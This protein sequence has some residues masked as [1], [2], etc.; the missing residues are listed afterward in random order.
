MYTILSN[1]FA[2][3]LHFNKNM[4]VNLNALIRYKTIDECLSNPLLKCTIEILI[5]RCSEKISDSLGISTSVSE[6]TIRNDIRILRSD[7]LGFNAPI[8]VENGVY[9]YSNSNYRLHNNDVTD[10][11]LLK[12]IQSLLIEN[13][14]NIKSKS[15]PILLAG[16][17]KITQVPI[18]NEY[19]PE[20]PHIFEK[21]YGGYKL[22]EKE[23]LKQDIYMYLHYVYK[24]KIQKKSYLDIFRRK[25]TNKQYDIYMWDLIFRGII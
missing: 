17:S 16:L 14:Y 18:P 12:D 7:I 10:L 22:T 3:Y 23:I 9:S 6:R 20:F 13:F 11:E 24:Q 8:I 2:V 15:L 25:Q 1:S 19:L 5:D 4:P 21:R